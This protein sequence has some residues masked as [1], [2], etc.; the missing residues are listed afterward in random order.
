MFDGKTP[1]NTWHCA[2]SSFTIDT[3]YILLPMPSGMSLHSK[4]VMNSAYLFFISLFSVENKTLVW[5]RNSINVS[6]L[7]S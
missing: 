7:A 4:R 3:E 1:V 6:F 5:T 2:L